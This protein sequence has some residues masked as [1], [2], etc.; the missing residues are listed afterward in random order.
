LLTTLLDLDLRESISLYEDRGQIEVEIQSDK[1][2]LLIA[3]RRKRSFA[4]QELLI[5]LDDWVHNLLAVLHA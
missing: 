1:M 4:A 2:G 3:R 5:L